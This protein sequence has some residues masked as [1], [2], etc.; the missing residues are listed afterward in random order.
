MDNL[1]QFEGQVDVAIDPNAGQE[2]I[3]AQNNNDL[4]KNLT[5][6][7][8]RYT[9]SAFVTKAPFNNTFAIGNISFS[10]SLN[11]ETQTIYFH[12][13]SM[14]LEDFGNRLKTMLTGD[15]I[16]V[17]DYEG[18]VSSFVFLSFILNVDDYPQPVYEVEVKAVSDNPNYTYQ[19]GDSLACIIEIVKTKATA[20][21]YGSGT[22]YKIEGNTDYDNLQVGDGYVGWK[23]GSSTIFF[24]PAQYQGGAPEEESSW[25]VNPIEF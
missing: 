2:Q 11:S 6:M 24:A 22:M 25:K 7:Q 5:R 21:P 13:Q 16:R 1:K 15:V 3:T 8:G 23:P 10:A 9:G 12:R 19:E 18:R 20:I 17:K 14:D 4:V